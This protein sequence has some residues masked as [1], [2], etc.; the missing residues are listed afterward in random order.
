ML[1]V[2]I[3]IRMFDPESNYQGRPGLLVHFLTFCMEVLKSDTAKFSRFD[4]DIAAYRVLLI[5]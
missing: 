2:A 5:Q 1:R 4:M 3:S